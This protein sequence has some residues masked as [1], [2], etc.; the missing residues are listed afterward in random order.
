MALGAEA[1][2]PPAKLKVSVALLPKVKMPVLLN[3]VA[4]WMS[5]MVVLLPCKARL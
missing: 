5:L 1:V 2:R 4:T 3:T